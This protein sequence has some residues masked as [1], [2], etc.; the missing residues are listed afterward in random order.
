M[1]S[2]RLLSCIYCLALLIG[3]P[4]SLYAI[5]TSG[6]LSGDETWDGEVEVTGDVRVPEGLSLTI[7][8]DTTVRFQGTTELLVEGSLV[9]AGGVGS[10][11][12]FTSSSA[13]P[14]AGD[15]G[16]IRV[17]GRGTVAVSHAVVEYGSWGIAVD[18]SEG[19][20][21]ISISESVFRHG[22]GNG[23][24]VTMSSGSGRTV[25]LDGNTVYEHGGKGI[26]LV[27]SGSSTRVSGSISDNEVR[28][29]GGW[30]ISWQTD[31]GARSAL[32]VSGNTVYGVGEYGL[33]GY[34]VHANTEAD[35]TISGNEV[36]DTGTGLYLY[37]RDDAVSD[38]LVISTNTVRDVA[39]GIDCY[40]Y[41]WQFYYS[42]RISVLL[43]GNQVV[44]NSSWGI[45][46]HTYSYRNYSSR[47]EAVVEGNVITG[48]GGGIRG[49]RA[50]YGTTVVTLASNEITG[51][52]GRG[53]ELSVSG[54]PLVSSNTISGN[55]GD[56]LWV[57]APGSPVV[58]SNAISGNGGDGL[59]LS[60]SGVPLIAFNELGGNSGVGIRVS[61]SVLSRVHYNNLG[62]DGGHEVYNDGAGPV[63]ARYNWWGNETTAQM[64]L[65]DNPKD[66][67][68][69]RDIYDNGSKGAVAY[70]PWLSESFVAPAEP[71]S[72]LVNPENGLTVKHPELTISGVAYAVDGI[73]RV[74]VSVDDGATW[75]V[76]NGTEFWS[77]NWTAPVDGTY[78]IRSRVISGDYI[79]APAPARYQTVN[80]TSY[81]SSGT[82]QSD[83]SWSDTVALRGD[84][85]VPAGVTLTI[86]PGTTILVPPLHDSTYG[87]AA[88]S[89][90]ELVISG[91]LRALGTDSAPITFV[92]SHYRG[93]AP[94]DWVGIRGSGAIELEHTV[95]SDAE[96]G[97]SLTGG[98]L[99]LA[100]SRVTGSSAAGITLSSSGG[101]AI[102]ADINQSMFDANGGAGISCQTSGAD[103][104]LTM[105]VRQS[106][107]AG[108]GTQGLTCTATNRSQLDVTIGASAIEHDGSEAI[109]LTTSSSSVSSVTIDATE[110]HGAG[111]GVAA[112]YNTN[113]ASSLTLTNNTIYQNATGV[114][115]TVTNGALQPLLSHNEIY[116]NGDGIVFVPSTHAA[117]ELLPEINANT[118]YD[119]QGNGIHLAVTGPI[120]LTNNGLYDSGY[121]LYN[122][123][124]HAIDAR[125]NWWGADTTNFINYT[126]NPTN[127]PA[128]YDRYDN[129]LLGEVDYSGWLS[130]YDPPA[131]PTV[132]PV[133][134]PTG[135][136]TSLLTGSKDA[137]TGITI[138]GSVVVPPDA[139]ESWSYE[140]SLAEGANSLTIRSRSAIGLLSSPVTTRI[141]KDTTAPHLGSSAPAADAFVARP[142][143]MVQLSLVEQSTGLDPV[144]SGAGTVVN[145]L[146][147]L[148]AGSWALAGT[149]LTFTPASPLSDGVYT[150]TITPTD[151]PLGNSRTETVS[152]TVDFA[153][154]AAPNLDPVPTPTK[155]TT[156][157]L[158]GDKESGTAILLDGAELVSL[159]DAL[160]WSASLTLTEG[161]NSYELRSR[162]RAGNLSE[163]T[164][165]TIVRDTTAPTLVSTDPANNSYHQSPPATARFVFSE[166]QTSL[167]ESI[168]LAS[169]QCFDGAGRD[170]AGRWAL[171]DGATVVFTPAQP[172]AE[173]LFTLRVTARDLVGNGVEGAFSF[174]YDG[175]APATPTLN[176]VTSPTSFIIQTLTGAKEANS[177][178]RLNGSQIIEINDQ[179]AWSHQITLQEGENP[180]EITSGDR[181]GNISDPVRATII[182]DETPP[183]SVDTLSVDGAGSGTEAML[184]WSG[185]DEAIQGDVAAYRIY[186]QQSLFT[187]LADLN[188]VATVPAGTFSYHA[189]SLDREARYFFAVVAVDNKDNAHTSV[190][191]VRA[192]LTDIEPPEP[193]TRLRSVN[194]GDSLTFTWTGSVDSA[195]DLAGYELVFNEGEP[196]TLAP[197]TAS[198][199][200][201]SLAPATGYPFSITAIDET[202]N[203][204]ATERITGVTVLA[205]PAITTATPYS[206]YVALAWEPITPAQWV[207]Q[208]L[209]YVSESPF[210]SVAELE[211]R[212]ATSEPR[213]NIARLTNDTTYYF[214]VQTINISEGTAPEVDA[215]EA[216]PSADTEGPEIV[217][218]YADDTILTTGLLVS[219]AVSISVQATDPIAVTRVEFI[220]DEVK[221]ATDYLPAP[222]YRW[223]FDPAS[224][225]DGDH[226][227]TIAA[228][229]TQG[230]RSEVSFAAEIGLAVPAAPEILAPED[231]L[232]TNEPRITLRGSAVVGT[233]AELRVNGAVTIT[234]LPVSR[235]GLFAAEVE[236]AEG[237]N[238]ITAMARNRAG[239][240]DPSA[241]LRVSVDTALPSAPINLSI[242]PRAS[243][244][245]KL[246]WR[247]AELEQV[248]GYHVYRSDTTFTD[249]AGAQR[250]TDEPY[251]DVT[252]MDL[253][254]ED[255]TWFYRVSTVD[256]AGNEGLLSEEI[257]AISDRLPP[258]AG[259]MEFT[260]H[261]ATDGTRLA[262]GLLELT[263]QVNEPLQ[264][265][266]F[267]SIVPS[268]GT[269][270]AVRMQQ[271]EE[272]IYRGSYPVEEFTPSG[273]ASILFS[274]R[275][276]AGNRGTEI[277]GAQ[278]L[279]IDTD[280]PA[281][282]SLDVIPPHPIDAGAQPEIIAR[283]GLNEPV[284]PG[285]T[286]TLS[287]QLSGQGRMPVE[288]SGITEVSPRPDE[289]QAWQVSFLLPSDAGQPAAETLRFLYQGSDDL[290]N[291]ATDIRAANQFQIYQ[292]ELPPLP[293]PFGFTAAAQP[294]GSVALS[295][296]PVAEAA[297]YQLYR[298]HIDESAP[299]P[300]AEV[301]TLAST[302]TPPA[303]G[304]WYY[305][306]ATLRR[307]GDRHSLSGPTAERLV[308]TDGTA[309]GAPREL[310]LSLTPQ[311]IMLAWQPPAGSESITYGLYRAA[312]TEITSV[313]GLTPLVTGIAQTTVID[314]TP[315][316]TDHCYVI[317]AFDALGNES[318]P[319][320]SAYRNFAL[321][322]VNSLTLRQEGIGLP[323]LSWNHPKHTSLRGYNVYLQSGTARTLLTDTPLT[324]QRYVDAGY[325]GL[326]RSFVVTAVDANG[327]ESLPHTITLPRLYAELLPDNVI[328]RGV[329][330]HLTYRLK[331]LGGTPIANIGLSVDIGGRTHGTAP[332]SLEGGEFALLPLIVG[333]YDDL[334]A[335]SR[336]TVTTTITPEV[337]QTIELVRDDEVDVVDGMLVLQFGNEEFL[338]GGNGSVWFR[339]ENS[340]DEEIE[341]ITATSAGN[342]ASST[343]R[344][345]LLD[346]DG[347]L[348]STAPYRE[349]GGTDQVTLSNQNVVTRIPAGAAFTSAPTELL[350]P[351][352]APDEVVV[353]LVIDTVSYHQTRADEVVM[354]GLAGE[355][356]LSLVDTSYYGDITGVNPAVSTG[357]E[358]I[359]IT[360][361]AIDRDSG[362]SL[363][364]VPLDVTIT[365]DGYE[366]GG[367]VYTN[368]VGGFSYTFT[369][370]PEESG[371]YEV[372]AVHPDLLDR[373]VQASFVITKVI[374]TPWVFDLNIPRNYEYTI[375]IEVRTGV[376]TELTNLRLVY[377]P[378]DQ[379]GGALPEG[380]S[381]TLENPI[382]RLGA[383]QRISLP[384]DIWAN[385]RA[386]ESGRVIFRVVSDESGPEGWATV[387]VH[388]AFSTAVP[389]LYFSPNRVESG[390]M[391]DGLI[392]ETITLSNKGLAAQERIRLAISEL[393]GRPA[394]SW[395]KLAIAPE[396]G[397]LEVGEEREVPII[398]APGQTIAPGN[399]QFTLDIT[400]D[401][402]EDTPIYLFVTV[403]EDGQG[404]ALFKVSD[405]Y[406]GTRNEAGA[407]VEGLAGAKILL[408]NEQ[409][410]AS[411]PLATT[412][413]LGEVAY[414][415]LPAGW[416]K[417]RVSAPSHQEKIGRIHVK[418]GLI[419]NQDVFLDYNLVT[420]TWEVTEITI[421]DR[422]EIILTLTFETDVPAAV[423]VSDPP[424]ITLPDLKTGM[425][426]N[427]EFTL[428]NHGFIRAENLQFNFP[429][430]DENFKYE[431]LEGLP[432]SLEAK[433]S[434]TIPYRI[435][436][437]KSLSQ[438]DESGGGCH[439][440]HKCIC[441]D[442]EYECI[443]GEWQGGS[444]CH[445]FSRSWGECG[446]G[447]SGGGSG[448][449]GGGGGVTIGG[450]GGGGS[451]K[452]KPPPAPIVGGGECLPGC[453]CD[454]PGDP[455]EPDGCPGNGPPDE[456]EEDPRNKNKNTCT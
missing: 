216:T 300:L 374:V 307:E 232:L 436:C 383:T 115:V 183:L 47:L 426:Y 211:P 200:E 209:I 386:D 30:G 109:A 320:N 96:S 442:Y 78:A 265:A 100:H 117:T 230:N 277:Q 35:A 344:W 421:E 404:G 338:R 220:I 430:D 397:D 385:N 408:Q 393:D 353:R 17:A 378:A 271:D 101:G 348:L 73:D 123:T 157:D 440:Y 370:L 97:L 94:G 165:F 28:D 40:S 292:D 24:T 6:S 191:P 170:V 328:R 92:S 185:Y 114:Q 113:G 235:D 294:G 390:V 317:T 274:G 342:K 83:E 226:T 171:V 134:T 410:L 105:H 163:P 194:E 62:N 255:T 20:G 431:L 75:Q 433:Q 22:T 239:V 389:A 253:T 452:P 244:Q 102:A 143:S 14:S 261:G 107:V 268:G 297:G 186:Y 418:P 247:P 315:S 248:R 56:G 447:G 311:G 179:T 260:H 15:W 398:F 156:V 225:T 193:I 72:R 88:P 451:S 169:A 154:P 306:L 423:V 141:V 376:G 352:G 373:S 305:S 375:P 287:Y 281:V 7:E 273:T 192:T 184:D 8:P 387:T 454:D 304:S 405:I 331:N 218:V 446:G 33:Y 1:R 127:L 453:G 272:L 198:H 396:L 354:Q 67:S 249:Q 95:I 160:R 290:D 214:A 32:S 41:S 388:T 266:P 76:A 314:P 450:G 337:G 199:T 439:S 11:I 202:G 43:T 237:D 309:P 456:C 89:K 206:G 138:N 188:P 173:D 26:R 288:L 168:T 139:L 174:T 238:T 85:R 278:T 152:F 207:K 257:S 212:A 12:T 455:G 346:T 286:P 58:L 341:I 87:G 280:G 125:G 50:G 402:Y 319:S 437:L 295:W 208:Y 180:L 414:E 60:S 224:F 4:S 275:D 106:T 336:A 392:T 61:N 400:S 84:I 312:G 432:D 326:E 219:R 377:D 422:Y 258:V 151:T 34:A 217:A 363:A 416:Y 301:D 111:I 144:A 215:V 99:S 187:Q 284:T 162:D 52:G 325:N 330:N 334:D 131:P 65:G 327:F 233:T 147:E 39:T 82:V 190:T 355:F 316:A 195:L 384:I 68:R 434:I 16:G 251:D 241:P 79:E 119:N 360:G 136:A 74:E 366:R 118:I 401:N 256:K 204:S 381:V 29:V 362:V 23:V 395:V 221:Q 349:F 379:P 419:V 335:L 340:G 372:R 181:A 343:I 66:I 240:S 394:P 429:G 318:A 80:S 71:F 93:G 132:D 3:A 86:Q 445:C 245:L 361:H 108:N 358:D 196:I 182:Y 48:N 246:R 367:Q 81:T 448:G 70:E 90:T 64:N 172:F 45:D 321:L 443:N 359:I 243:G 135:A 201:H 409:T 98:T 229:D 2:K 351:A 323:E 205:N 49:R 146:G 371:I 285:A 203:R 411:E 9:V 18:S 228:Y 57:S 449:G 276:A 438:E 142:V 322:P 126:T 313:D 42:T 254:P 53:A 164:P 435:T 427:G 296:E 137:D 382:P 406:T 159:D 264:A 236:L 339:L 329:M 291:V 103:S 38:E 148:V 399:Y 166:E 403:N 413:S 31:G 104:A 283:F 129:G 350:V 231:R 380:V 128:I 121:D 332:V 263:V 37:N 250:L 120:S 356:A 259:P 46:L 270:Y 77:Y 282:I 420:V 368:E 161:E 267:V 149:V 27:M 441:S 167:D 13:A 122:P 242:E 177:S 153:P 303:E 415:E 155:D 210:S 189:T 298:R 145:Q 428:T 10:E 299:T 444:S 63:D 176:P 345:Q 252:F 308:I 425:V 407:L 222:L 116:S 347:N 130:L 289:A 197:G 391:Q 150:V 69:I 110:I 19:A 55:G 91:N 279:S 54:S 227:L 364:A 412:D 36:Y 302:D 21:A 59:E 213:I 140:Y 369:P 234:G 324:A 44:N 158:A 25:T 5:T 424:S 262:P 124:A 269:P 310:T 175:T 417:Y 293:T 357:D 133:T 223:R 333:G 178:I 365:V 112:S 51:N